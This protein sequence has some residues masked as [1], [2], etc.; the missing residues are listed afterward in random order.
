[1]H[2]Q[3]DPSR[4]SQAQLE[5]ELT[6]DFGKRLKQARLVA[7]LTQEALGK[8]LGVQ[9]QSVQHWEAG[10]WM[11][12]LLLVPK[13]ASALGVT[14]DWLLT[15]MQLT[16]TSST[17]RLAYPGRIVPKL[18]MSQLMEFAK[19]HLD[20]DEVEILWISHASGGEL[21]SFD[22]IDESMAMPGGGGLHVGTTVTIDSSITPE[23]GEIVAA[24][25]LATEEILLRRFR[26][27]SS[28]KRTEF[29]L[30]ADNPDFGERSVTKKDRSRIIGV[31]V[32]RLQLGSR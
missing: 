27:G 28:G 29:I 24:A 22:L 5:A 12:T 9:K 21:L 26:P 17:G 16:S 19:G 20:L 8:K 10:R 3:R 32:E 15:G 23:P 30:K 31:L 18:T 6:H 13:V 4:L 25:L 1:V 14:I 2:D 11:P 7:D